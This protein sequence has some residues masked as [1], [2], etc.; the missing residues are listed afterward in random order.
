MAADDVYRKTALGLSE[1][2]ERKLKLSP[3]L[4]TMLILVDGA[5]TEAQLMEGAAGVGAPADF[6]SQLK[7]A[8][9][10]ELASGDSDAAPRASAPAAARSAPAASRDTGP[11]DSFTKF[12][13]AKNFMNTTIVEALGIKSFMFTMKLERANGTEELTDLIDAFR[14]A[15]AGAKGDD[16]A[17]TMTARL[18]EML[19]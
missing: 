16:Y 9:L 19:R 12:R 17:R 5:Q 11:K 10:I 2:K 7:S 3:R 18:K 6:L 14:T 1:I 13:E 8:G 4:R 15:L